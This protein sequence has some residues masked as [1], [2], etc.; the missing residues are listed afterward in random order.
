M[1]IKIETFLLG[2]KHATTIFGGNLKSDKMKLRTFYLLP[3]A[4]YFQYVTVG[5]VFSICQRELRTFYLLSKVARFLLGSIDF[6]IIACF[7]Q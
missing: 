5:Y 7:P 4:T 1:N 6:F 3:R 2:F